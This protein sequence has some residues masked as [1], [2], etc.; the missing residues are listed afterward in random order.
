MSIQYDV[1]VIV[2][3]QNP[4][5]WVASCAMLKGWGTQSSV[6]VGEFTGGLDPSS[7]CI[8]NLADRWEDCTDQMAAWG[9]D[10]L[11]VGDLSPGSLSADG[12]LAALSDRGPAVLLHRCQGFPYGSQYGDTSAMEGAH[13][14]LLTGIDD[15]TGQVFFNN[16][17]GDKDQAADIGAVLQ[18]INGDAGLG[19]SLGFWPKP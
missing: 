6:G 3:D 14:I 1:E 13:A 10:V 15:S 8:A 19:K 5:C 7:S 16:P 2:Q 17:W 11:G 12:L 4:I 18:C 9:F